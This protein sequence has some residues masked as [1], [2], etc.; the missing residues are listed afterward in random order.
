MAMN[1]R[2]ELEAALARVVA[3]RHK[4]HICRSEA[5]ANLARAEAER[6]A[7]AAERDKA[8]AAL[9]ELNHAQSKR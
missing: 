2:A 6:I 3:D 7:A 8:S 9:D 5:A 4:A 1:M